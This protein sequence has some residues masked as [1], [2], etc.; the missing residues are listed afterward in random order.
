MMPVGSDDTGSLR[1]HLKSATV[2]RTAGL[3]SSVDL[4][5]MC[6]ILVDELR[7]FQGYRIALTSPHAEHVMVGLAAAQAVGCELLLHRTASIPEE[8]LHGWRISAVIDSSLRVTRIAQH[9]IQGSGIRILIATSGTT[10][11][12]KLAEHSVDA[13]LGR[14]RQHS[15]PQDRSRWLLTYDPATFGGLQVLLTALA[16]GSE[17]VTVTLPTIPALSEAALACQPTHVSATPTFW[18]S[19]LL[20]L[21]P[22]AADLP[23]KQITLGGEIA[24]ESILCRL[25]TMYKD[26]RVNHI[27]ASTE[28]GA[29]FSVQDGQPGF[30][31]AWL[32]TGVDGVALRIQQGVLQVRSPRAMKRYVN[33]DTGTVITPDGWF[34]TG[35]T[36]EQVGDRVLFRG[37]EDATLNVGGGK[38]RP[39][40]VE[41]LL[42]SLPEVVEARVYGV[43]NPITGTVVGADIVLRADLAESEA[44]HSILTQARRNLEG[45]KVPRVLRFVDR[46]GVSAA[47]KKERRR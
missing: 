33:K 45:Y 15:R 40:E 10:S 16:T 31:A 35:D 13:L 3:I 29:L 2:R 6:S 7:T 43:P 24:D 9:D 34:I 14:V 27:Y 19:F 42:L 23:L 8:L 17:L 25:R 5:V 20:Y 28:A 1:S 22:R 12:P 39:E 30:P 32:G 46:I 41:A 18:R 26:A 37:R 47:G 4:S 21:G 11:E 38:V 44:R 36:V